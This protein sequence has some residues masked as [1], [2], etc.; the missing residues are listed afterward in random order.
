M[1]PR[2]LPRQKDDR[3]RVA[4]ASSVS[5]QRMKVGG[6]Y[7]S[8]REEVL[9]Q[10]KD[11][12]SSR[13]RALQA[14]LSTGFSRQEQ[15]S[16]LPCPPPGDLPNPGIKPNSPTLQADSLPT[17]PPTK[18]PLENRDL[19]MLRLRDCPGEEEASHG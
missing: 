18:T 14:P 1:L 16:G 12:D 11:D 9:T 3:R 15:W 8:Y 13:I 17:E 5:L 19:Q 2:L 7:G 10:D 6:K 4:E